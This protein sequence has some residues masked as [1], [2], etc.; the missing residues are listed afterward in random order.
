MDGCVVSWVDVWMIVSV[1]LWL[2]W[3]L[4]GLIFR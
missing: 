4:Y 1:R 3:W 2:F